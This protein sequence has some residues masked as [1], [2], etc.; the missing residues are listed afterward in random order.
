MSVEEHSLRVL[1]VGINITCQTRENVQTN[2]LVTIDTTTHVN[3]KVMLV[4]SRIVDSIVGKMGL[5]SEQN[6]M[7]HVGVGINPVA[8]F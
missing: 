1:A 5:A 3:G 7:N 2:E 8:Q 4:V 6:V